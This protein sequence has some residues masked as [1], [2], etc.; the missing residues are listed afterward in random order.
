MKSSLALVMAFLITLLVAF[1]FQFLNESQRTKSLV[2]DRVIDGDT[3]ESNGRSYRLANINTPEKSE[4]GYDEAKNFLSKFEGS[5]VEVEILGEDKYRRVL[6]RVYAPEYL[7]LE[8]ISKGLGKK[9]LVEESELKDFKNAE[10]KAISSSLGNWQHSKSYGCFYS[11]ISPENEIILLKNSC[12]DLI[13]KDWVIADESRKKYKLSSISFSD[14]N[15]HTESGEDNS[16][17]LFWNSNAAVWNNDRDTLY[18]FDNEEKIVHFHPYGY[19][20]I[21]PFVFFSSRI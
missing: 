10:S 6:V 9:F 5:R 11:E 4:R 19:D 18:I 15:F 21:L 2:I 13:L 7:N 17:D 14:I 16:T 12:P 8:I 1:N 20:F 3:F